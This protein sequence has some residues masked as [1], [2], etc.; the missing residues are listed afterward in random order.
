[1]V[2]VNVFI[3]T[4]NLAAKGW[5]WSFSSASRVKE[6]WSLGHLLSQRRKLMCNMCS[7]VYSS[8][9]RLS[10]DSPSPPAHSCAWN[11]P[12]PR[13][14]RPPLPQAR[15]ALWAQPNKWPSRLSPNVCS[16]SL[17]GTRRDRRKEALWSSSPRP[18]RRTRPLRRC[19]FSCSAGEDFDWEWH[20]CTE[21]P[22]RIRLAAVR[23]RSC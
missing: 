4:W 17:G 9:K 22:G 11:G 21:L 19:G 5:K 14:P 13:A 7:Y 16:V 2:Q 23:C 1:M 8:R 15:L 12:A 18:A 10:A 6:G 20:G 3:F